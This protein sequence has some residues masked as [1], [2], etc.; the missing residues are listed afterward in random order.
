MIAEQFLYISRTVPRLKRYGSEL[1]DFEELTKWCF[2][3]LVTDIVELESDQDHAFYF[4]TNLVEK[5]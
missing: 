2:L 5:M 4:L 1:L 3:L